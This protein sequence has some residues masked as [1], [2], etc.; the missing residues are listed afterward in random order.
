MNLQWT[1][2]DKARTRLKALMDIIS[3]SMTEVL[4]AKNLRE[5]WEDT[6]TNVQ[7]DVLGNIYASLDKN[8]ENRL[9]FG[10]VAHMDTVA[11]QITNILPNGMLQFRS[12]GIQPH[13]LLG[14]SM[15]VLTNKRVIDGVIGFDPTSQYGQPKGLVLDDLWMDIGASSFEQARKMIEVGN[16]AV[17][18]PRFSNM[19]D[20]TLSGTAIDN[21]VGLFILNECLRWFTTHVPLINLYFIGT[22]QEEVG[23]RGANTA[24]AN[25]PLDI[26]IILDVDYATDT[27]ASHKNQM[28]PLHL[29][30]GVGLHA[31]AD[32]NPVLRRIAKEVAEKK[33]IPYQMSLGRFTYGG[34][35]ASPLQVQNG[36]VATLNI[37]IPCRYMHSPVEMCHKNDVESA[38]RLIIEL[39]EELGARQQKTFLPGI[40]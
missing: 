23:L 2:D 22:V 17:L 6:G 19:G 30:K 33:Q 5:Q 15:K 36:G 18:S 13:T 8:Y 38:I 39:V 14:Q 9:N 28:G 35:D 3:P 32:N 7:T 11:I 21:R 4:M 10:I 20:N 34:T 37:N 27:P 26:C 1:F 29:G 40:D 12:I 16:L 24:I 25:L 31:K